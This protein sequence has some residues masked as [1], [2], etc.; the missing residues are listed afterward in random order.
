M[1]WI[2]PEGFSIYH[3]G[4]GNGKGNRLESRKPLDSTVFPEGNVLE[5]WSVEIK[6]MECWNNGVMEEW[7]IR[8]KKTFLLFQDSLLEDQ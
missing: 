5:K 3:N 6:N 1:K 8:S 2:I 4:M 7:E